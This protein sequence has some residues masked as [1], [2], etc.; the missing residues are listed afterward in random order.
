MSICHIVVLDESDYIIVDVYEDFMDPEYT[1]PIKI[2][3]TRMYKSF[4][5]MAITEITEAIKEKT[6]DFIKFTKD[7]N[8]I[9]EFVEYNVNFSIIDMSYRMK[10]ALGFY[11]QKFPIDSQRIEVPNDAWVIRARAMGYTLLTPMWYILSNLGSPN[12]VSRQ[13]NP[14][15]SDNISIAMRIQNSFV[16]KQ[17]LTFSNSEFISTSQAS[18]LS[19]IRCL[20]VDANLE[21]IKFLCPIA[22]TISVKDIPPN[23][24]TQ[25]AL[26]QQKANPQ[27]MQMIQEKS[28]SDSLKQFNHINKISDFNRLTTEYEFPPFFPQD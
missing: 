6:H 18:S 27:V 26:M 13:D 4:E 2:N 20:V 15:Y 23:Q 22:I 8:G 12:T 17:P 9:V 14:W 1:G 11:C 3:M 5:A 25:E 28:H 21:P 10:L 24:V 16:N 7:E 19:N